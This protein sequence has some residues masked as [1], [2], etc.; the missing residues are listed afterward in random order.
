M[1]FHSPNLLD[2]RESLIDIESIYTQGYY[3]SSQARLRMVNRSRTY[4]MAQ[5]EAEMARLEYNQGKRLEEWHP[6]RE[7]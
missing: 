4:T 2:E 7:G 3:G 1:R 5:G 6:Q